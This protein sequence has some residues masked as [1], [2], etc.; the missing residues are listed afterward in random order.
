MPYATCPAC[1]ADVKYPKGAA[2][3]STATCPDCDEVFV[4]PDLKPR[5]KPKPKVKKE[6]KYDPEEDEDTY[7]V[8]RADTADDDEMDK[9]RHA[10]AAMRGAQLD[11]EMRRERAREQRHFWFDGPEIWLLIFALGA[12]VGLPFGLWLA[13]NSGRLGVAKMFWIFVVMLA[14]GAVALGLGGSA[15]AWLRK[16]R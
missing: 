7:T 9:T 11:A 5:P 13:R 2:V 16:S 8:E 4:P 1:H 6:K 3:G 15:W 12:G 10:G 14:V